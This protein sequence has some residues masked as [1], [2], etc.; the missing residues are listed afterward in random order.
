MS[1]HLVDYPFANRLYPQALDLLERF[2]NWGPTI[3][4]SDGDERS[5]TLCRTAAR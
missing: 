1:S 3:I 4:L 2:R 5:S